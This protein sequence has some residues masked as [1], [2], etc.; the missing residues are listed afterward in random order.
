MGSAA[1]RSVASA[2]WLVAVMAAV[3]LSFLV[4]TAV[5]QYVERS[6]ARHLDEI[7]GNAMPSVQLLA[8]VSSD[9]R[10][11]DLDLANGNAANQLG[12]RRKN[13]D[14][15][16]AEYRALPFFAGEDTLFS[17]LPQLLGQLDAQIADH[18]IDDARRTVDRIDRRL[19]RLI[20]YD[21]TQ[22]QR[23]A[24]AIASKRTESRGLVWL[25]DCGAVLL[26]VGAMLLAIRQRRR[27][28]RVLEEEEDEA[29][30]RLLDLANKV[31][32]LGHF[33]GRVAHD[34]RGPLQTAT[35]S[36]EVMR[37]HGSEK[38]AQR[39][40]NALVQMG[41]LVDGLLE[42]ARAGGKPVSGASADVTAVVRAVVEAASA[43][44]K[45]KAIE[46]HV[47][48]VADAHV[49]CSPGVL[50]S[51]VGNLV[52]NAIRHMN[53]SVDREIDVNVSDAGD[54]WRI[55][56]ADTGP[57]I[58]PGQE[59]RIFDPYVQLGAD[60]SGLGLGLATVDRLVRAHGGIVGVIS[61]PGRGAMFW[62]ELPRATDAA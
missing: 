55:E 15:A 46:L 2:R 26:A 36:L 48:P 12:D 11:I 25:L 20:T 7:V 58:P 10:R 31:D 49:A 51:I 54:R 52:R 9:L 41:S 1:F 62:F 17:G 6:S 43:Q 35:M 33:A 27:A 3:V 19:E 45:E 14:A 16:I 29:R 42:F 24:L 37:A 34:I 23:L 57:G 38:A 5:S 32:E 8:I 56:V 59:H 22:G 53:D 28:L 50:T 13:I 61:P 40:M 4:A 39:G 44:A 30:Q 21:A 47:L 18:Q 60:K